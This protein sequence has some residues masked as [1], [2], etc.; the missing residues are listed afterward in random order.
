MGQEDALEVVARLPAPTD[1]T[2][3]H[4]AGIEQEGP[5]ATQGVYV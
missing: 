5:G 1:R 3:Q 4:I 2:D